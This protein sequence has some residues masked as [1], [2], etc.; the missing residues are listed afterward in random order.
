MCVCSRSPA[1]PRRPADRETIKP[2]NA[3]GRSVVPP[4]CPRFRGFGSD[5]QARYMSPVIN[6]LRDNRGGDF[7]SR[8]GGKKK[9]VHTHTQPHVLAKGCIL[10]TD[11]IQLSQSFS[12]TGPWMDGWGVSFKNCGQRARNCLFVCLLF[13]LSARNPVLLLLMAK[14]GSQIKLQKENLQISIMRP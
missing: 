2:Q 3:R 13:V 10:Y 5:H 6:C 4:L 12:H 14:F 7:I 1:N 9:F 8:D 11:S